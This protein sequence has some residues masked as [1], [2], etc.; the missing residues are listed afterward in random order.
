MDK[1]TFNRLIE[2][3]ALVKSEHVKALQKIVEQY[4]YCQP[5]KI[6]LT[7]AANSAGHMN[8]E[9]FLHESS[10]GMLDRKKLKYWISLKEESM[11]PEYTA[12]Q[13]EKTVYQANDLE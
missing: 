10:A 3:P 12:T 6:L 7:K 8:Y 13:I 1:F 5:A 11:A 9:K 4:P 2:N